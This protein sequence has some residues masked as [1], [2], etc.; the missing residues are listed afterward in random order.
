MGG[1]GPGFGA[2]FGSTFSDIF[3]DIFGMAGAARPRSAAA[4][5]API[6]ATTWRSRSEEAFHGKTAQIAHPD[7]GDLRGLF[8]HRRQGRHQAEDLFDLRRRRAACVSAQGFFTLERTC[9]ACQGRGQV[10]EDPCPTC[11]GSGR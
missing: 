1:G 10:I 6:C 7:L 4:S 9:P 8:G 2:D 5:A 11:S 3:E